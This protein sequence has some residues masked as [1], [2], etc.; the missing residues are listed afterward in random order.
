ME[1]YIDDDGL[2]RCDNCNEPV[3]EC[4]CECVECGEA[5]QECCCEEGPTYPAVMAD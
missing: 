2:E 5:V 4:C 1:T 3:Q